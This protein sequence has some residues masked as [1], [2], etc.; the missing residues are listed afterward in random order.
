LAEI[1]ASFSSKLIQNKKLSVPN[2]IKN[3]QNAPTSIRR[4]V[5]PY[6]KQKSKRDSSSNMGSQKGGLKSSSSRQDLSV[7]SRGGVSSTNKSQTKS[8]SNVHA[9]KPRNKSP[10]DMQGASDPLLSGGLI[11]PNMDQ[12]PTPSNQEE[13]L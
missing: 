7:K 10:T 8:L 9:Y 1:N 4:E 3:V 12:D 2:L 11:L 6:M 5:N 13:L